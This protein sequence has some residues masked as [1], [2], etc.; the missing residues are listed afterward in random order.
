M[1]K[2]YTMDACYYCDLAKALLKRRE[3]PFKEIRVPYDD[4]KQWEELVEIY[5]RGVKWVLD[6]QPLTLAVTVSTL[7]FTLFLAWIVPKGSTPLGMKT[8][9]DQTRLLFSEKAQHEFADR[10]EKAGSSRFF[11]FYLPR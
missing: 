9:F 11:D 10:F 8:A 2:I 4:E 1:I 7:L 6:H 3:V 5:G